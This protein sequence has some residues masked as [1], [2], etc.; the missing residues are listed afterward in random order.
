MQW[1]DE[2]AAIVE[3]AWVQTWLTASARQ[4]RA[5]FQF[6]SGRKEL[7][8]S[9]PAG[10]APDQ[11]GVRLDGKRTA[12]AAVEDGVLTIP[13]TGAASKA[14]ICWN[15]A[16]NSP[17]GPPTAAMS[18]EL[19]RLG[20]KAWVRRMYWQLVLPRNEHLLIVAE[21]FCRRIRLELARLRLGPAAAAG[22]GAT[23][24]LGGAPRAAAVPAETNDY[25]FS[26]FGNVERAAVHTA[27]RSWIVLLASGAALA[28]GLVLIYLPGSRRPAALWTAA[29]ALA[30]LGLLYPEPA[31]LAAQAAGLGL[32]LALAAALLARGAA[33]RRPVAGT[34]RNL[35][36]A[37][38]QRIDAP[39][40]S[41]SGVGRGRLDRNP[42][43]RRRRAHAA[44][45]PAMMRRFFEALLLLAICHRGDG[46]RGLR[47]RRMRRGARSPR[48]Q[49]C[50]FAACWRRPT[51]F[52]IGLAAT[53]SICPSNRPSSIVFCPR[54]TAPARRR[55]SSRR[56]GSRRPPIPP[57]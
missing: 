25:L 35:R 16:I 9:I 21:Q 57:D 20:R 19:P 4:D 40:D 17:I 23:G 41:A 18:L 53:S 7:E 13:L 32:L 12:P 39:A 5:V 26:T 48:P 45:T 24:G 44:G 43:P 2:G 54:P 51:A 56:R 30:V 47:G 34:L 33:R 8:V 3:R 42:E 11:I 31:W 52:R 50:G 14:V 36:R 10:V 46:M 55:S 38:R 37:I 27:S 28:A 29:V 15:L 49:R 6:T 22:P 1:E